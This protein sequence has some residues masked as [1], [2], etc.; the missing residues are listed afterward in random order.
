M[1]LSFVGEVPASVPFL[2]RVMYI[3]WGLTF[4]HLIVILWHHVC[5]C[6]CAPEAPASGPFLGR[7]LYIIRG[8][9]AGALSCYVLHSH[10]ILGGRE[11]GSV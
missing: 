4:L 10:H 8:L 11:L 1:A 5:Y 2:G 9:R 3:I 7:A 6:D